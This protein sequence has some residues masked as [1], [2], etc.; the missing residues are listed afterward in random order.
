MSLDHMPPRHAST[1]LTAS[2]HDRPSAVLPL[3]ASNLQG[4]FQPANDRVSSSASNQ[5]G[6]IDVNA[7]THQTPP[8]QFV[9]ANGI[10]FG[11]QFQ[12]PQRFMRNVADFLSEN[13]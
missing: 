4:L 9:E 1:N 11:S 5:D 8:T 10:R 2:W 6:P 3:H 7:H 12:Y 13:L